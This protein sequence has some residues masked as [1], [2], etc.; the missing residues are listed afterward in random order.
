MGSVAELYKMIG[1][2]TYILGKPEIIIYEESTKILKNLNKA[3]TIAIGDS[4]Y[5]DIKGANSFGIDSLLI[6]SGIH[7]SIFKKEDETNVFF[8]DLM[9]SN[10]KPTFLCENFQF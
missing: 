8:D 9:N 5:H 1:G 6:T 3:R 10:N 7:K 2:Q 4:I